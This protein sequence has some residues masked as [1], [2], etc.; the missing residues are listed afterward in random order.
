MGHSLMA[1][2]EAEL[3][4]MLRENPQLTLIDGVKPKKDRSPARQLEHE[5][6]VKVI[7]EC[8]RRAAYNPAWGL[9]FAIP[10]GGHRVKAV[11]GKLK[12]EGVRSG[13]PDLFLPVARHGYY[14][15]FLELKVGSNKPYPMQIAWLRQLQRMGY[16]CKVVW[17][18]PDEAIALI[19]WYLEA[20]S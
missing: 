9:I 20:A 10:N 18:S 14:G 15:M 19:A 13:I 2:S 17:D 4:K 6:Q 1:Y 5:M 7:A 11:A 3:T 16:Y 12:A 8:D